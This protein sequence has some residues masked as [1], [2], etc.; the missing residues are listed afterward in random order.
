M[1]NL[2]NRKVE[3]QIEVP[4]QEFFDKAMEDVRYTPDAINIERRQDHL[5]FV[6]D[7]L[8]SHRR[9]N[10]PFEGFRIGLAFTQDKF[11]FMRKNLGSLTQGIPFQRSLRDVPFEPIKGE[12][13]LINKKEVFVLDKYRRNTVQFHRIRVKLRIPYSQAKKVWVKDRARYE[14][15]LQ[16]TP[17]MDE[18]VT[19]W[20]YVG[21]PDYWEPL[22]NTGTKV[23]YYNRDGSRSFSRI[24]QEGLFAPVEAYKATNPK[25]GTHYFFNNQDYDNQQHY[26]ESRP[27]FFVR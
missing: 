20:M 17:F 16:Q 23:K 15:A 21:I 3:E 10:R 19:A 26:N 7:E 12:L 6:G 22:I 24:T 25:V 27:M 9:H 1:L 18:D 4:P 13:Y 2:F 5:L 14:W 11:A 8:M